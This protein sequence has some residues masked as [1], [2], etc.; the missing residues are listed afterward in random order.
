MEQYVRD[1]IPLITG[2]LTIVSLV[3]V[4]A[5]AGQAIPDVLL[6]SLPANVLE[7]IP[8]VNAVV[9]LLAIVT[10]TLGVRWIRQGN[11]ARHRQAMVTSFGLFALFLVLYLL[12]VAITGPTS[13]EGP[14]W[15]TQFV[16]Y[17]MLAIHILL[18]IL[19]IPL[20]YYAL[21]LA[22]THRPAELAATS[23]ARVGRI[24]ATMWVVSF[25]LGLVIYALL[26]L[27]PI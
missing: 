7:L 24:A 26:Y 14:A 21:L 23:H 13:F 11:V 25:T 1:R 12:K 6:P 20:V 4:F 2:V 5:A 22:A 3:L 10:I 27:S 9:S 19:T 15:I 16:Y 18:A 17:P 8:H